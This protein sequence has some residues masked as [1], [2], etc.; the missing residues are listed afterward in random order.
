MNYLAFTLAF[1]MTGAVQAQTL[2]LLT[3]E[4]PPYNFTE[5]GSIR[6]AAVEQVELIMA[7]LD[8][9]YSLD[10][11]PW[12]RAL[13][14]TES[15][16][17]TCLFTTAHDEERHERFKWV[18]PLLIDR[19]VMVRKTGSGINPTTIE[20]AKN[21]TVGTQRDDFSAT[22]LSKNRFPKI[23]LAADLMATEKKLM[24]GRVDL[25]MTSEKTF[26]VMREQGKPLESALVLE[27]RLYGIACNLT[28]PGDLVTRMQERLDALIADGTQKRIFAKYALQPNK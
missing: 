12:A 1:F 28:T 9:P 24:S 2:T 27:G 19:M 15:Q 23:D 8:I 22:F 25:M 21:F 14:L 17:W 5:N 11:L 20:E 4:Y 18:E 16:P 13:A 26:Q 6:G 7:S 3:E 10:I